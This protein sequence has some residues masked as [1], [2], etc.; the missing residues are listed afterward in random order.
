MF[1]AIRHFYPH[2]NDGEAMECTFKEY[3]TVEKAIAYAQRYARGVRFAGVQIQGDSG[4]TVYE[5]TSDSETIDY[6]EV[7]K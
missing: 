2:G 4:N 5:I 7:A 6:R 3:G 1:T